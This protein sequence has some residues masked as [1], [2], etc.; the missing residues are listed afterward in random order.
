MEY[1]LKALQLGC[2]MQL[3]EQQAAWISSHIQQLTSERDALAAQ[4]AEARTEAE[5]WEKRCVAETGALREMT[6]QRD[7]LAAKLALAEADVLQREAQLILTAHET[8]GC[9]LSERAKAT[10]K[11]IGGIMLTRAALAR[12]KAQGGAE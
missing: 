6:D 8:P 10:L 9:Q 5:T 1:L 4:L 2:G 12:A 7:A 11:S 3:T